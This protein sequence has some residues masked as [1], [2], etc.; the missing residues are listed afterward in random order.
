MAAFVYQFLAAPMVTWLGAIIGVAL[1]ISFPAPPTIVVSDFMPVL[2]GMLSLGA[3]RTY[4]R[5]TGVPGAVTGA[6]QAGRR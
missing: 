3:M 2:I 5:T 6:P 1:G 4:E